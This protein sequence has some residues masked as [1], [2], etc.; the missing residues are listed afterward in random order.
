MRATSASHSTDN[1]YA[2]LN[3]PLRRLQKVNRPLRRLQKVTCLLVVFSILFIS[4]FPLP[5]SNPF[6]SS[7]LIYLPS[8]PFPSLPPSL[9]PLLSFSQCFLEPENGGKAENGNKSRK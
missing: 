7:G 5:I 4:I 2:F 3:R 6:I 8:L 1:S 9:S